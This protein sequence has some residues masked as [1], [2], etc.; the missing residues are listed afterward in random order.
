VAGRAKLVTCAPM[1]ILLTCPTP[2][3]LVVPEG[4]DIDDDVTNKGHICH[5]L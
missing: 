1:F 3:I 2:M 5:D 4:F